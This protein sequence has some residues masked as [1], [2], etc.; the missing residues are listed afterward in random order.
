MEFAHYEG[1]KPFRL[2]ISVHGT[3]EGTNPI[4][5]IK[6]KFELIKWGN[7]LIVTLRSVKL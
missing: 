5:S 4:Y 3:Y 6:N 1:Y 2:T 7:C